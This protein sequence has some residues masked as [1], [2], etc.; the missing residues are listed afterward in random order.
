MTV[1]DRME[2]AVNN[3]RERLIR[4]TAALEEAGVGYAVVGG[5]AVMLWVEANGEGGVRFTPNVD[6]LIGRAHTDRARQTLERVGF[7]AAA[8]TPELFRDGQGGSPRNRVRLL[9]AHEKVCERDLMANPGCRNAVQ[10]SGFWV[11]PL[12]DLVQT[13]LNAYRI[14]DRVHLRDMLDIGLIDQTWTQRYPPELADRL[15]A[16][17][18]T[19][20]G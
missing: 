18:D 1:L 7:V 16:L 8:E 2:L 14:V 10:I 13:K 20:N 3:V 15:Q 5:N 9:F 4:S 17:I 6:L 19:P 12:A 11:L